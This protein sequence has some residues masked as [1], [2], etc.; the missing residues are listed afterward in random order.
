MHSLSVRRQPSETLDSNRS[1]KSGNE[2]V[3]A[4]RG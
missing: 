1:V 4:T 3:G 2:V